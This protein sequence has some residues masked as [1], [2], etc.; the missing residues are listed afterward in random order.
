MAGG[1]GRH[2]RFAFGFDAVLSRREFFADAANN[3]VPPVPPMPVAERDALAILELTPPVTFAAI[4][5]Q[6][7]MLVK[8][9][10]PDLHGGSK[11]AEE[12]FKG[13]NQAFTV[14]REIYDPEES[15]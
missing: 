4:K 15:E 1:T 7:K 14:L 8:R 2:R 11:E 3:P 5:V 12:R 6:Y 9:H 13:I 10:H